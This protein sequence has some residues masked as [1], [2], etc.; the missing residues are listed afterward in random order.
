MESRIKK[1]KFVIFFA[2]EITMSEKKWRLF[3]KKKLTISDALV[4]RQLIRLIEPPQ[5]DRQGSSV[6]VVAV[7][8]VDV[9]VS[10]VLRTKTTTGS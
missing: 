8:V 4:S 7:V 5:Q 3:F 2:R 9:E 10:W 1:V 6:V